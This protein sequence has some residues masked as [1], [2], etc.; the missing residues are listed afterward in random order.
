MLVL[1]LLAELAGLRSCALFQTRVPNMGCVFVNLALCLLRPFRGI[2][3]LRM[4]IRSKLFSKQRQNFQFRECRVRCTFLS[5]NFFG[6]ELCDRFFGLHLQDSRLIS[7]SG[8]RFQVIYIILA[9]CQDF[10]TI[11]LNSN[12][13]ADARTTLKWLKSQIQIF[14]GGLN[15]KSIATLRR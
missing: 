14:P 9:P 8:R 12:L 11:S 1:L 13:T 10:E 5:F 3:Q 15:A 2:N 6:T 4:E 7:E